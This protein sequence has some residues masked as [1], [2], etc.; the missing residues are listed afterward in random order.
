MSAPD[1][2]GAAIA[3]A[4]GAVGAVFTAIGIR[5]PAGVKPTRDASRRRRQEARRR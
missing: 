4:C 3:L 5:T 2:I 1:V